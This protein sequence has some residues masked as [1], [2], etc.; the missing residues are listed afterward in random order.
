MKGGGQGALPPVLYCSFM[1]CSSQCALA[2][3]GLNG[4]LACSGL[5]ILPSLETAAVIFVLLG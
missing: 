3:V 1:L 4:A 2:P 5:A